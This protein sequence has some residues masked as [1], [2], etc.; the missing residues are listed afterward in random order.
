MSTHICAYVD[1]GSSGRAGAGAG[2]GGRVGLRMISG[3]MKVPTYV[4]S[5]KKA[6]CPKKG[7]TPSFIHSNGENS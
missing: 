2:A 1:V 6:S 3:T 7:A 5:L 4:R